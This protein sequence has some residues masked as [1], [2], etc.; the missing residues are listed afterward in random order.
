MR[1]FRPGLKQISQ[2]QRMGQVVYLTVAELRQIQNA[3]IPQKKQYLER[4]RD[5]CLFQC[6][7]GGLRYSDLVKLQKKDFDPDAGKSGVIRVISQKGQ[8]PLVIPF[9]KSSR[10]IFVIRI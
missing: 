9:D 3:E 2:R 7:A 5:V 4:S 6:L 1:A 10:R 8:K